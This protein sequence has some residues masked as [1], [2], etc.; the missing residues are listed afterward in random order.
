[1][2][3]KIQPLVLA[4]D[5]GFDRV[6]WAVGSKQASQTSVKAYGLIQTAKENSIFAR[7]LQI[8]YQLK[9]VI[10]QY[11]PQICTI[12][13]LFFAKNKTT[14]LQVAE[15]RGIIILTALQ[16]GL[17]ITEHGPQQIKLAAT[18]YGNADKTA[19][20]KMVRLQLKLPQEKINDDVIDALA[21]LL[22][23]T[24]SHN[25]LQ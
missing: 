1:M 12:E 24:L 22:T 2:T 18:G 8:H 11:Q 20:A 5:P 19:V 3:S 17:K 25:L 4:I 13:K 14:A 7:Y 16:A 9:A 10:D 6:G 21:L 23:E 15:A